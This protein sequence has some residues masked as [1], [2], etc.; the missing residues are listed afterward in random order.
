MG[1]KV[2]VILKIIIIFLVLFINLYSEDDEIQFTH[3]TAEDGLSL[4]T[5]TK[6]LQDSRGF[7]WFGTYDGLN[8]YD[9]YNFKIFL[10][11]PSNPNSISGHSITA[12]HED[13]EGRLKIMV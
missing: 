12:L 5:V 8:R 11:E 10:P 3:L 6:I 1:L 13:S 7:L 2:R 4:N 9:G